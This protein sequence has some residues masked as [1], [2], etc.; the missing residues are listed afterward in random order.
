MSWNLTQYTWSHVVSTFEFGVWG[1]K[2]F[3]STQHSGPLGTVQFKPKSKW[4]FLYTRLR[5]KKKKLFWYVLPLSLPDPQ[6]RGLFL[7]VAGWPALPF[8][9]SLTVGLLSQ[10]PGSSSPLPPQTQAGYPSEHRPLYRCCRPVIHLIKSNKNA[11][12]CR[13]DAKL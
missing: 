1:D 12:M 7:D 5:T 2:S 13:L 10:L 4:K 9:C 3:T 11:F 6:R 8:G